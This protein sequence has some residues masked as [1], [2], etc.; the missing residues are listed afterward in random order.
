[1]TS[2]R[3]NPTKRLIRLRFDAFTALCGQS[4]CCSPTYEDTNG[5]VNEVKILSSRVLGTAVAVDVVALVVSGLLRNV[6]HGIGSVVADVAWFTFLVTT[7]IVIVLA[8]AILVTS[9]TQRRAS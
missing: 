6:H 1:M 3:F 4:Y 5:Q 7:L 9:V 2:T 8:V